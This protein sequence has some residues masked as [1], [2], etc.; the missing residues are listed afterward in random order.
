MFPQVPD[1]TAPPYSPPAVSAALAPGLT[2]LDPALVPAR[3]V[4]PEPATEADAVLA[5]LIAGNARFVAGRP[6]F[7]H[8]VTAARDAADRVPSALVVG[9]MDARVPVEAV[10]DQ[11]VGTMCA[12]RTAG[13]VLD[14]GALASVE[15]AVQV[16]GVR[17]IV[18]L[19]HSRCAAVT[20]AVTAARTR[21]VPHGH[22]GYAVEE[23]W[24]AVPDG[25]RDR[26]DLENVVTRRHTERVVARLRVLLGENTVRVVGGHYDVGTGRVTLHVP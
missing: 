22:I 15:F 16:L 4:S 26:Y 7:G 18:V 21:A 10:F 24:P 20:A 19:G 6:R 9:C 17:L 25:A 2:A 5:E 8:S 12:V 1:P 11:D 23:I 14:R 3:P 13:H